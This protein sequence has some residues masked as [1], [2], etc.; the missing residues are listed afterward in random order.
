[1]VFNSR[2]DKTYVSHWHSSDGTIITRMN[3]S[4]HDLKDIRVN[5]NGI[6]TLLYNDNNN[7]LYAKCPY[8]IDIIDCTQDA[9]KDP[10]TG[11]NT[12]GLG[13]PIL[14]NNKIYIYD[15]FDEGMFVID[16]STNKIRKKIPFPG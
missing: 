7:Y 1:M 2:D 8:Q 4:N 3:N 10:I 15:G 13:N 14:A 6:Q 9:L 16:C 5:I 12:N 11:F